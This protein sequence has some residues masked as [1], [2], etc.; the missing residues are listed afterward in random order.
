MPRKRPGKIA[1]ENGQAPLPGIPE[2]LTVEDLAAMPL[3]SQRI[4]QVKLAYLTGYAIGA[5]PDHALIE[6]VKRHGVLNPI[7]LICLSR[8][9]PHPLYL[10]WDGRRRA[11]A[12]VEAD[13]EY[14]P[15]RVYPRD[16]RTQA[17]L[18]LVMNGHRR[19]NPW[20]EWQAISELMRAG[21]GTA[22]IA[23]ATKLPIAT[24]KRRA[25]LG[26][27]IHDLAALV[28]QG[29]IGARLAEAIAGLP[30]QHQR[31]LLEVIGN[32]GGLT[33]SDVRACRRVE[34]REAVAEYLPQS[35][36]GEDGGPP[37]D[38]L[39]ERYGRV[40][41]ALCAAVGPDV[42]EG[43]SLGREEHRLV[44]PEVNEMDGAD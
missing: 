41:A 38:P 17:L 15:A 6:S 8:Q 43:I 4:V 39:A 3:P 21:A 13:L 25:K 27:L 29:A 37:S 42:A 16:D 35:L 40:Y 26:N 5:R 1:P 34:T 11:Q 7:S 44:D 22:V 36:F 14:V 31:R 28:S 10:V 18:S 24:I 23:Q 20:A 2:A 32:R 9:P 30:E 12:A 33:M 19:P